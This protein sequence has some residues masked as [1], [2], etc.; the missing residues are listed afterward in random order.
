M[1][2]IVALGGGEIRLMET[3]DIDREIIRLV[4]KTHPRLSFL[5]TASNDAV[6]YYDSI[7]MIP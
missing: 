7:N 6:T 2:K 1:C 4:G 5:P 3:A